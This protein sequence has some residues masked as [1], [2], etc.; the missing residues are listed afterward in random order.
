MIIHNCHQQNINIIY[1]LNCKENKITLLNPFQ[2]TVAFHIETNHSISTAS[3][4][5]G[6]YMKCNI[7]LKRVKLL[8][9]NVT[10]SI[11]CINTSNIGKH[12]NIWD[13]YAIWYHLFNFK[14]VKSTQWRSVT[15][16]KAVCNF[17]KSNGPPRMFFTFFKL[18]KWYKIAQSVTYGSMARKEMG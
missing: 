7:R 4:M 14:N 2:P 3:Q 6:F 12:S 10:L 1:I 9:S 11:L 13:T 5:T 18:Y 15:L 16:S 17:T 8:C